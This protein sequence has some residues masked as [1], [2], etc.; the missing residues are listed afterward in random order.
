[1]KMKIKY[2]SGEIENMFYHRQFVNYMTALENN[3]KITTLTLKWKGSSF[4]RHH[5]NK[6]AMSHSKKKKKNQTHIFYVQALSD[7]LSFACYCDVGRRAHFY[8]S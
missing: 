8:T 4:F 3:R 2:Y 1:M 5:S 6:G 7:F